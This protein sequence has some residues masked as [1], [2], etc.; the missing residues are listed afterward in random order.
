[1][2]WLR[3]IKTTKNNKDF[4][5]L[6]RTNAQSRAIEDSLRKKSIPYRIYGGLSFYKRKEIKL[7][8]EF[9]SVH[10][11]NPEAP[12]YW[13]NIIPEDYDILNRTGSEDLA[14]EWLAS[15]QTANIENF[16]YYHYRR[17]GYTHDET[18]QILEEQGLA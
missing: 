12:S 17:N 13:K 5:I 15:Q 9:D 8:D 14:N 2:E 10:P 1:M 4:A 18:I 7:L 3:V 6:Y 11:G 16:D